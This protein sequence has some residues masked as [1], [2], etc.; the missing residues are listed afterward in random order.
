MFLTTISK[1]FFSR[2]VGLVAAMLIIGNYS[3]AQRTTY[4]FNSGWKVF[5]GDAPNAEAPAFEDKGWKAVT[6]PYAWNEDDAF[7]KDIADLSTGIAWYRKHFK[8]PASNKGQKIFV[9]FE[10]IRQAGDFYVNGKHIGLHEN[11]VMAFGFDI[12]ELVKFGNEENVI[13]ARIDNDWNYKEKANGQKYQWEDKNFNA[14]ANSMKPKET[15]SVFNHPPDFAIL[16]S[17][18]GKNANTKPVLLNK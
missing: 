12:T 6:L 18:P 5:V 10:G 16:L 2:Q 7:K 13:A 4:N 11:G 1:R 15:L 9:E 14:N 17:N 8:L 3:Y